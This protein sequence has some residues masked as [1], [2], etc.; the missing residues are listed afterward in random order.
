MVIFRICIADLI[1]WTQLTEEDKSFVWKNHPH[2]FEGAGKDVST[3]KYKRVTYFYFP[4]VPYSILKGKGSGISDEIPYLCFYE[5]GNSIDYPELEDEYDAVFHF[6]T[7]CFPSF[8]LLAKRLDM[9]SV[10]LSVFVPDL[11]INEKV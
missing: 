7:E 2:L 4:G 10:A 6:D 9:H 3:P 11:T 5:G 1:D 8:S